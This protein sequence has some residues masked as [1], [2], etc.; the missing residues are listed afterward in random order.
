MNQLSILLIE[1]DP[2]TNYINNR[3]LKTLPIP[4]FTRIAS[5]SEE[6]IRYL[7]DEKMLPDFIFLE[8]KIPHING[9]EFL[10]EFYTR[11]PEF[12]KDIKII[13]LST[14]SYANLRET[15]H[16]YPIHA[17]LTKPLTE[18]KMKEALE[19]FFYSEKNRY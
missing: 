14:I 9:V 8:I 13:I 18:E 11:S 7:E 19:T 15:L 4:C 16:E 1:D 3:L 5:S 10:K 17:F 12:N 6:A 2:I